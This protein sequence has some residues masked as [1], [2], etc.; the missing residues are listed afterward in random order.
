MYSFD[1]DVISM[2]ACV[3]HTYHAYVP[4]AC[5]HAIDAFTI[6]GISGRKSG[7][8]TLSLK[9]MEYNDEL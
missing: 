4:H 2:H 3:Y 9:N 1:T 7:M 6:K 8:Q 5:M